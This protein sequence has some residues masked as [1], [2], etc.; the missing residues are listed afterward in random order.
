MK[1][2]S[3]TKPEKSLPF[4]WYYDQKIFQKEITKI[5]NNEWL[6]VCHI[7]SIDKNHYRTLSVNNKKY[8]SYQE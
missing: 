4:K 6:Y 5:F 8:C 7:S 1:S 2:N 3:L